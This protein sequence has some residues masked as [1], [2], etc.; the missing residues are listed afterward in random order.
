M[1]EPA[2]LVYARAHV[3]LR[4]IV[5][6]RHEPRILVMW[7][8]LGKWAGLTVTTDEVPW[9]GG[10][11][12]DCMLNGGAIV[13]VA[14]AAR[15]K[16]WASW[17]DSVMSAATRPPLGAIAVFDRKGGGHVGFVVGIYP[18]GDL[19]ILGGNQGN[20]VNVRRFPRNPTAGRSDLKLIALRWPKGVPL[21][22]AAPFVGGAGV[23]TTGE[24]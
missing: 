8:R 3:G 6:P 1:K 23:A 9:C 14:I 5:G 18:N 15:A 4:E 13:P 22:S 2:W 12:G 20:A 24:A 19:D 16:A 10:F 7:K 17:G 21:S 11:V